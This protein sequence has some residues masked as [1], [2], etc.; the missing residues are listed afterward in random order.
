MLPA[1][2]ECLPTNLTDFQLSNSTFSCVFLVN[3]ST[4]EFSR[5]TVGCIAYGQKL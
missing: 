5:I 1:W 2:H 4:F 3:A